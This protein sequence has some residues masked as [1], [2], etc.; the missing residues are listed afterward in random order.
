MP[1]SQKPRSSQDFYS[2]SHHLSR[3]RAR[4]LTVQF[5][6]AM[7]TGPSRDVESRLAIFL[8]EDGFAAPDVAD[9]DTREYLSFLVR[10][11]WAKR[12]EIENS[13]R[14]NVTGWRPERMVA[15]DRAILKLAFF[16]G[17]LDKIV[18]VAVAISEAVELAKEFGTDDSPRFVNG[19]LGKIAR[20]FE[21]EEKNEE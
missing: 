14:V 15:V 3:H 12:V 10:G 4:E 21:K 9:A 7:E 17:F 20:L 8:S 6:Y 11:I 1:E 2:S 5:L 19:V 13:L 16:E 18:P